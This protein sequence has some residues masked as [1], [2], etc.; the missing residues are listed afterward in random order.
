MCDTN[1]DW[2]EAECAVSGRQRKLAE[3]YLLLGLEKLEREGGSMQPV[4]VGEVKKGE[5]R[6]KRR[7]KRERSQHRGIGGVATDEKLL[8]C[9]DREQANDTERDGGGR[10]SDS[11]VR[12]VEAGITHPSHRED[13][14]SSVSEQSKKDSVLSLRHNKSSSPSVSLSSPSLQKAPSP[15]Q[16]G[17]AL[18]VCEPLGSTASG[19]AATGESESTCDMDP[20]SESSSSSGGELGA[21]LEEIQQA[22]LDARTQFSYPLQRLLDQNQVQLEPNGCRDSV[23]LSYSVPRLVS[24]SHITQSQSDPNSTHF[25]TH[26]AKLNEFGMQQQIQSVD[27]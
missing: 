15:P 24:S 2:D 20:H 8:R 13:P 11:E 16:S 7:R 5:G 3:P 12:S 9:E 23:D 1:E 21:E 22:L 26:P 18:S 25:Q 19:Y 6:G 17:S 14:L 4:V 10:D 27:V